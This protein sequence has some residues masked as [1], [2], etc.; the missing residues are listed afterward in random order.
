MTKCSKCAGELPHGAYGKVKCEYCGTINSVATPEQEREIKIG[1][2]EATG[3]KWTL[4]AIV[5]VILGLTGG[6]AAF[7]PMVSVQETYQGTETELVTEEYIVYETKIERVPRQET[8]TEQVPTTKL[9]TSTSQEEYQVE[10]DISYTVQYFDN[11]VERHIINYYMYTFFQFY[12]H[13]DAGGPITV[14]FTLLKDGYQI[15][16]QDVSWP[17]TMT[18]EGQHCLFFETGTG[19]VYNRLFTSTQIPKSEESRYSVKYTMS[20]PT[21]TVTKYRDVEEVN[22][23]ADMKTVTNTRTVYDDVQREV[24]VTKVREVPK[25]KTVTKTRTVKKTLLEY[26]I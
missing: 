10:E 3:K 17:E 8:Y 20:V 5:I 26:L 4:F 18:G 21:K 11:L 1:K 7:V 6:V 24:P 16:Y 15:D 23:V 25:E 12:L 2:E 14:R 19:C 9:V 22:T 13:E